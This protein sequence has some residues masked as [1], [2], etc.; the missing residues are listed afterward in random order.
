WYI[1]DTGAERII[2]L[3]GTDYHL[4][5]MINKP[6]NMV[7]ATQFKPSKIVVDK[8]GKISVIVQGSY[9]GIIEIHNNGSFSRYFGL[10]K[11]RVNIID[12]F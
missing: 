10:N 4:K 12:H 6:E 2:V 5:R 1:A 9:E 7:G 3:D 8:D 11:P